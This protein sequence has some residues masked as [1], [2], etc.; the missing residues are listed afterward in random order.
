MLSRDLQKL[1]TAIDSF[2]WDLN[3]RISNLSTQI[4]LA[5]TDLEVS[6]D[7]ANAHS[8]ALVL[9]TRRSVWAVIGYV[10]LTGCLLGVTAYQTQVAKSALQAQAEPQFNLEVE[11]TPS[12]YQLAITNEGAYPLVN[13]SISR[14]ILLQVGPPLQQAS[15]VY[16]GTGRHAAP[17]WHIDKLESGGEQTHSLDDLA[18]EALE[19][20]KMMERFKAAGSL[21][22]IDPKAK[23]E[24]I[25]TLRLHMKA[26][27]EVDKRQYPKELT[28]F[29]LTDAN[30]GKPFIPTWPEFTPFVELPAKPSRNK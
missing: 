12:G 17:W 22:G 3:A 20:K 21:G 8:K 16:G 18:N 14:D 30:T 24:F 15:V 9:W 5:R 23:V 11:R 4:E 25:A 28:V 13:I 6:S 27:R 29:V 1:S 19:H 26:H 7:S 2:Q 10:I